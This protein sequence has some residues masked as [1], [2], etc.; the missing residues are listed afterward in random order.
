MRLTCG[1][2]ACLKRNL[3]R[4]DLISV[5]RLRLLNF[6]YLEFLS[7]LRNKSAP[8]NDIFTRTLAFTRLLLH[9]IYHLE[10]CI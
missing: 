8:L 1:V 3:L 6:I 10:A 4:I 7:F 2:F 5:V 9:F